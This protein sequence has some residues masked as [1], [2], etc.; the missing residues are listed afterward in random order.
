VQSAEFGQK[1]PVEEIIVTGNRKALYKTATATLILLALLIGAG[2]VWT[3]RID[4]RTT[5]EAFVM[6]VDMPLFEERDSRLNVRMA[7]TPAPWPE[8]TA[9]M[10]RAASFGVP[11]KVVL[12]SGKD[13][14]S[15]SIAGLSKEGDFVIPCASARECR[16]IL[17]AAQMK[18]PE[19]LI[20]PDLNEM[21]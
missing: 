18:I 2:Y 9:T 15:F 10:Y 8:E 17:R 12:Q 7:P 6:R 11:V 5:S 3:T 13:S 20:S 1:Q 21:Q 19:Q 16:S 4:V 14:I